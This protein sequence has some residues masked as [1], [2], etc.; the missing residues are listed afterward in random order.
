[1]QK[2]LEPWKK[3][4]FETFNEKLVNSLILRIFRRGTGLDLHIDVSVIGFGSVL[5]QEDVNK[6]LYPI[7]Y[8]SSQDYTPPPKRGFLGM[9]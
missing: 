4:A 5:L 1:M 7:Y 2:N 3:Q 9:G 6:N 8:M